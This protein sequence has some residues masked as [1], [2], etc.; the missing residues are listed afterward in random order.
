MTPATTTTTT[1]EQPK[2]TTP[3]LIPGSPSP[4]IPAADP[5]SDPN[6]QLAALIA[7][8]KQKPQGEDGKAEE[9]PD[10]PAA[11]PIGDIISAALKFR[12]KDSKPADDKPAAD[13]DADKKVEAKKADATQ[14]DEPGSEDGKASDA[15]PK[16]GRK[17]AAPT[18]DPAKIASDAAAAAAT[19]AVRAIQPQPAKQVQDPS[20]ALS[21]TLSEEDRAQYEVAKFLAENSPK[22][23]GADK[24][25]LSNIQKVDD[26]Q[27]RWQA[28]NPGK[29]FNPEDEEH[30]EFYNSMK[31]PW[32]DHEFRR[33]EIQMEA[34]KIAEEKFGVTK[35]KMQTMEQ[36]TARVELAPL[37]DQTTTAAVGVMA[38]ALGPDVLQSLT[39]GGWEGYAKVDPVAAPALAGAVSEIRPILETIIQM[40]DP[41][42]RI[43]YDSKNQRHQQWAAF[44]MA[45]ED[46][47]AGMQDQQGRTFATRAEYSRM[48]EPQ[49]SR[50]WYLTADDLASELVNDAVD[51]VKKRISSERERVEKLAEAM[52]FT[53][54]AASKPASQTPKKQES[55][56]A[57]DDASSAA[58]PVSPSSGSSASVD[59]KG[60][61]SGTATSKVLAA[62]SKILFN[63]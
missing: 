29:A 37:V 9:K 35:G 46:Q 38:K 48:S 32:S 31:Q 19:A 2:E 21:E 8:R 41:K 23:K 28:Q 43:A 24:V 18:I 56:P 12:Q 4:Q 30:S 50:H 59:I 63:R 27:S 53:R 58:K 17:K 25:F 40:D 6:N 47:M 62:T 45:K 39:E 15:A 1:T 57:P 33:A 36:E 42:G 61:P 10:K 52:G 51:A 7:K 14:T 22:H 34:A 5:M 16:K 60:D 54:Q 20:D 11:K 55:K 3:Q 44:L 26:Y 13:A 49:R